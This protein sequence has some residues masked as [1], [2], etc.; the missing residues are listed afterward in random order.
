MTTKT[1]SGI[2]VI[3]LALSTLQACDASAPVTGSVLETGHATGK[4]VDTRGEPLAGARILLDNAIFHAS[5]IDA[6]TRDDGT[7]R[8]RVQP[9]AW[10]AHASF[11][12]TY[13]GKTY[14]LELRPDNHDSFAD[15]GAVRNFTWKLEGRTPGNDYGYYGGFI[16]LSTDIGF[17]EDMEAIELTLT[18]DGPLIDGSPGRTLRLRM[19]D[20]YWV[21]RYQIEDVPIGR[22]VVTATLES[23]DGPRPLKIQDWHARGDFEP[24]FQLDF[25]PKS[26]RTPGI[27]AS[28]V[29]GQ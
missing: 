3:C 13:N 16:Q 22:Y 27:S 23:D 18:P 25:L 17:H 19:G 28:I 1:P 2:L 12:Q 4:V 20:H 9:G 8:I 29:I 26:D 10:K 15:E 5:Y 14:T 21:D 24:A 11:K 6:T 7:Y